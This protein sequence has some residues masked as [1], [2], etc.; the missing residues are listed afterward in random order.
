MGALIKNL[1]RIALAL[2]LTVTVFS[3]PVFVNN[4]SAAQDLYG[5]GPDLGVRY[6]GYS[7]LTGGDIRVTV[8]T[9]I[10][11]L[12]GLLGI[13][14][15]VIVIY[16]GFLWMTAGGNDEQVGKA[17]SWIFSGVIGLAIILSSYAI[18]LFI[19]TNLVKATTAPQ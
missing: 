14:F 18:T 1:N 5:N 17:K 13:I 3:S 10:R 12:L 19:T 16:G 11:V 15:V 4:T 2:L 8:A 7:T 6:P 9:V